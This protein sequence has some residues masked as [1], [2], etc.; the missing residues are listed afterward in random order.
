MS[1]KD[2][3]SQLEG[4]FSDIAPKLETEEEAVVSPLKAEPAEAKLIVPETPPVAGV[5]PEQ[6][7]EEIPLGAAEERAAPPTPITPARPAPRLTV[8]RSIRTRLLVLLLGLTTISVLA[9]AYLGVSSIQRVGQSAQQTSSEALRAQA[10]EYL[11]QLTL[12]DA[13]RND[14]ILKRVQHDAENVAQYAA[15]IFEKPDVFA[16][17]AYWQAEDHMFMGPDGQYINDGNDVCSVFVPDF[18]GINDALLT[19]LESGAYLDFVFPPTYESD[20]NTVAIYLGTKQET[21]RY[22]PNINLGTILPPDFQV[23]Q[24]PWYTNSP[25]RTTRRERRCG[26]Q[27]MRTRPV[28]A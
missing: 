1:D 22:Y 23:T 27:C 15:S 3:R 2:L 7:T 28:K 25:W 21:T 6:I 4:L 8:G 10:E 13:Q 24:R 20:P 17:G 16:R 9:V 11:R 5:E 12:G 26:R 18:V 14:L 19:A